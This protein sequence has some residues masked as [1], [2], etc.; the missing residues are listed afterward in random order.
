MGKRNKSMSKY[1]YDDE[2][3]YVIDNIVYLKEGV[4]RNPNSFKNQYDETI[5][6]H[7]YINQNLIN[8]EKAQKV[9][10]IMEGEDNSDE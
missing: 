8:A 5:E 1:W 2:I 7:S 6:T 9:R 3:E 10:Q 4:K